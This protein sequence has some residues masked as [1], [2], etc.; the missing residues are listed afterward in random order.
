[1]DIK[2]K[3]LPVG[4]LVLLCS[5][6]LF[7]EKYMTYDTI[8]EAKTDGAFE[9]GWL[10][11]WIPKN[12]SNIH[13]YHNLDTN[14]QAISFSIPSTKEFYLPIQCTVTNIAHVPSLKTKLFPNQVHL[15]SHIK[16]CGDLF[17]AIDG[18]GFV[19]AW[20]KQS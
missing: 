19:H 3:I 4:V 6:C 5:G 11:L 8:E 2:L 10:P 9:R 12:A 1:M 14:L 13:E 20:S 7:D 15:L 17:V 18:Q 16:S